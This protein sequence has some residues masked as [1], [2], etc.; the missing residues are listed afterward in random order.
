[1]VDDKAEIAPT[2]FEHIT[3]AFHRRQSPVSSLRVK[4]LGQGHARRDYLQVRDRVF[5]GYVSCFPYGGDLFIGWTLWWNLSPFRWCLIAAGRLW[6][7]LT[8]RGTYVHVLARYENGKA[9]REA[10]HGAAREGIDVASGTIAAQGYGTIGSEIPVELVAA[11]AELPGFI[12][13]AET[14]PAGG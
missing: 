3:W 9:L 6:Q 4:R 1:M 14:A 5:T 8:M 12:A 7:M 10:L 2:A 13:R 11:P